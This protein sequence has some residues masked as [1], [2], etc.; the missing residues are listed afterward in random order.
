MSSVLLTCCLD[1]QKERAVSVLHLNFQTGKEDVLMLEVEEAEESL[2]TPHLQVAWTVEQTPAH[3]CLK[4]AL[5]VP[6]C[7]VLI[8][9]G[10]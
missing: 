2:C 8:H 6:E 4:V 9:F 5:Y 10:G 7:P 3:H 1:F